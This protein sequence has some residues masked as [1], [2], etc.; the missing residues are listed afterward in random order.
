MVNR[1]ASR[2]ARQVNPTNYA[3]RRDEILAVAMDLMQDKGYERMT[4]DDVLT[5]LDMSKGAFYHYFGSK[6]ALLEGIVEQMGASAASELG[7]IVAD[8][9]LGAVAKLR[10]YFATSTRWKSANASA[11]SIAMRLWYDENNALLRM[12]L[13][14][15]SMN[16]TAPLLASIIA[17][18]CTE[19]AFDTAYPDEAATIITGMGLHL[20]D[21]FIAAMQTDGSRAPD[22]LGPRTQTLMKGYLDAVER[23]LG[24]PAGTLGPF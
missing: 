21:S 18:G 3:A 19:G 24:I 20:A 23:I 10:A 17:Q 5:R 9:A 6:Q 16:T 12:K 7:P 14:Q 13:S 2:V 15:Q 4:I 22:D 8:S 1:K 11:V